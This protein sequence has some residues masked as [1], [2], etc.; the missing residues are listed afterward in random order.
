M[1]DLDNN[2]PI[3]IEYINFKHAEDF[4]TIAD[5]KK[6]IDPIYELDKLI[7]IQSKGKNRL[8]TKFIIDDQ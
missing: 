8:I 7:R 2:Y 4:I 3:E 1:K 5:I 6:V